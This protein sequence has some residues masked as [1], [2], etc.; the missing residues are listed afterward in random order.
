LAF[1]AY[2]GTPLQ[3]LTA[4][5]TIGLNPAALWCAAE[6][7]NDA[8]VLAVVLAGFSLYRRGALGLGAAVVAFSGAF[9]LSGSAAAIP[10]VLAPLRARAGAAAGLIATLA[11]SFPLFEGATRRLAP[12]GHFFPQAGFQ[13]VIWPLAT[14]F[15]PNERSATLGTI[16]VAV[17]AATAL[18]CVG[19]MLLRNG[20]L[21]GWG[22]A[23]LAAW[24]LI[25][26]PYP[27]YG[28][29]LAAVAACVPGT[30]VAAVLLWLTCSS[31]LRYVPDA[32]GVPSMAQGFLLGVGASLPFVALIP[33][34]TKG[35][36]R[37]SAQRVADI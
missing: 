37:A 32:I 31:L 26:N 5:A 35:A 22:Y 9:K 34:K 14:L 28:L 11:L 13:A 12:Q 19:A 21:E 24:V 27:W 7:H 33:W 20:R 25:P 29:W 15:M 1:T 2:P 3:R 16:V 18:A 17:L 4:A 23:A 10:F 30:R 6:G 8:L 36:S